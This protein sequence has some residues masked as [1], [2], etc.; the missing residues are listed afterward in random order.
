MFKV[1][2]QM[3]ERVFL[4]ANRARRVPEE[5]KGEPIMFEEFEKALKSLKDQKAPGIDALPAELIK[6]C[7]ENMKLELYKLTCQIYDTRPVRYT[8]LYRIQYLEQN[9]MK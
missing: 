9:S 5:D 4:N 2:T 7:G 3:N 1:R 8:I 6:Q